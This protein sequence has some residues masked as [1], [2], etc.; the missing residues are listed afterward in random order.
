MTAYVD[1]EIGLHRRNV[2]FYEAQLRISQPDSDAD[3]SPP[4]NGPQL[5]QLDLELLRSK[6]GM[7]ADKNKRV[8]D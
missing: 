8:R 1:L 6:E 5:V 7:E 4:L 2:D 3:I